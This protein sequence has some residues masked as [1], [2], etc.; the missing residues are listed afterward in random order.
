MTKTAPHDQ[1]SFDTSEVN[2]EPL[3]ILDASL[4]EAIV[5][6]D[7]TFR[8]Q[9]NSIDDWER[10]T[11]IQRT[12]GN[13]HTRVDLMDIIHGIYDNDGGEA[14]LIIFR[15][16]FD[17]Q[18]NSRRVIRA[19]VNIEFLAASRDG[20]PP[21][22]EAIAPEER[23]SVLP[24]TDQESITRSGQMNLGASGVPFI[25]AGGAA[26]LEKTIDRDIN[27]A[28]TVTGS[29]NIGSG[30]NSGEPTA[31]VW[32]LQENK[33]RETGVPD[34]VRVAILLRRE[35]ST[36]FNANVT[37]EAD[38]DLLSSL[39]Q[40]FV[41]V[42]LDDPVLF[43][44]RLTGKK[45]KNNSSYN[46]QNISDIDLYSLCELRMATEASFVAGQKTCRT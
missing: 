39:E 43:N 10:R 16:R 12:R 46:A 28:T 34:S 4:D 2:E 21:I 37:L 14:T 33:R 18:K 31:A 15:F 6:D 38:V 42:P 11:V 26:L 45:P 44:P 5:G 27:D 13:I 24:T 29:I 9:N 3:L 20:R 32:N 22:V 1:V 23:W 7:D 8:T 30:K 19:R 41:K 36:P 40:K 17:P 25:E 35:D